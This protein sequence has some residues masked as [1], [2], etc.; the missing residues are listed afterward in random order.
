MVPALAFLDLHKPFY[1]YVD[2][3]EGIEKG[4]LTQTL[5]PWKRPM[6]YLP[7]KLNLVPQGW[8]ACLWIISAIALLVKDAN[9]IT[10]GQELVTTPHAIEVTLKNSPS[11]WPPSARLVHFQA[12]LLNTPHIRYN[13]SSAL[14]AATLL[15]DPSSDTAMIAL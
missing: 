10:M 13:P 5:G 1:L 8:P 2:E 4:V 14:N 3:R 9:K 7:K 11:L 6:A 12:L 15:L